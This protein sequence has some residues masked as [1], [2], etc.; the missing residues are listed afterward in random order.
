MEVSVS[1]P[2]NGRVCFRITSLP[3][4]HARHVI[5]DPRTLHREEGPL[6]EVVPDVGQESVAKTSSL[7]RTLDE[8]SDVHHLEIWVH[9]ALGLV[10]VHEPVEAL[11]RHV[12]AR[13]LRREGSGRGCGVQG[14]GF[15]AGARG[16][17]LRRV[18]GC[19]VT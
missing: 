18:E 7:G 8:P 19:S 9:D 1:Q 15:R 5:R 11:V 17:G 2:M 10:F 12:D 14:L 16:L 3:T 13:L 4:I 6:W